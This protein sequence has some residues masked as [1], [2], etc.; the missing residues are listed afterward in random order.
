MCERK[1]G[2]RGN[3]KRESDKGK[4]ESRQ[5][6]DGFSF[7]SFGTIDKFINHLSILMT[8]KSDLKKFLHA[9]LYAL[10]LPGKLDAISRGSDLEN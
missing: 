8:F 2:G 7:P 4:R 1:E 5:C 10:L 6:S 9:W 3:G